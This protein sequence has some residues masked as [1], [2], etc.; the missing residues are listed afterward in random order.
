M[1]RDL[2]LGW[3]LALLSLV[4]LVAAPI[5]I[6]RAT[7]RTVLD[8]HRRLDPAYEA[9][10]S[11][12]AA[13]RD[14]REARLTYLLSGDQERRRMHDGA[15]RAVRTFAG[16]LGE[17]SRAL[18]PSFQ[19]EARDIRDSMD[20]W[21]AATPLRPVIPA[22]REQPH[23]VQHRFDATLALLQRFEWRVGIERA[24]AHARI[25]FLAEVERMVVL[26][27][28]LLALI[29]GFYIVA[30]GRRLEQAH[31][32]EVAQA[33]ELRQALVS[34]EAH[35]ERAGALAELARATALAMDP[36]EVARKAVRR[37]KER[38][39]ANNVL[40]WAAEAGDHLRVLA[41]VS[42]QPELF[43][44]AWEYFHWPT[45]DLVT[46]RAVREGETLVVERAAAPPEVA[47]A[48]AALGEGT[49]L[50]MPLVARGR[51]AGAL[52]LALAVGR[53]PSDAERDLAEAIGRQ[54]AVAL[55][56][57]RLFQEAEAERAKVR[58]SEQ[59]RKRFYREVVLAVTGGRL[60]LHER[61]ETPLACPGEAP[62]LVVAADDTR[63]VRARVREH[64]A[65]FGLS[66]ER[67][68][69]LELA[70]AEAV[71]NAWK[72]AGGARVSVCE[73]DGILRVVIEDS[74][75]GI[76]PDQLARAAFEKGFSTAQTLGAGYTLMLALTDRV[77]LITDP[78]GTTLSLEMCQEPPGQPQPWENW[79][80][81]VAGDQQAAG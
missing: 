26:T 77:R 42:P 38:L 6:G 59:D 51:L 60:V 12:E 17:R 65:L 20:S 18:S 28:G 62:L 55:E 56:S 1:G 69:D 44:P 27:S 16:A 67:T 80:V 13:A 35:G 37:L 5:A 30:A 49:L 70:A 43:P 52:L 3:M 79:G 54:L 21:L 11:L 73:G 34:A 36:G 48:L 31:E 8:L 41:F 15:L 81:G 14:R 2:H 24:R 25:E 61:D 45:A 23:A 76:A 66:P 74:G 29:V 71:A 40:V 22:R 75:P 9:V 7:Q 46:A 10:H 68:D 57:A 72:H 47:R 64:A 50:A 33:V 63:T 78:Q 32:R 19:S 53:P 4:L 39:G 58:Q